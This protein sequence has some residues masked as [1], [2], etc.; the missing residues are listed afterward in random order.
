MEKENRAENLWGENR[1]GRH[2]RRENEEIR[3]PYQESSIVI[4]MQKCSNLNTE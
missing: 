4:T 3:K 2:E 1:D